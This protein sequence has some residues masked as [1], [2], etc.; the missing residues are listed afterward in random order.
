MQEFKTVTICALIAVIVFL[1]ISS[2][3]SALPSRS[4]SIYVVKRALVPVSIPTNEDSGDQSA[5][6]RRSR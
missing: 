5:T 6:L 3:A 4:D 2:G 1:K